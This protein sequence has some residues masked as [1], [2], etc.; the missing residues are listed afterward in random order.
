LHADP[1]DEEKGTESED[2]R[3]AKNCGQYQVQSI[4]PIE[5]PKA[6]HPSHDWE[7]PGAMFAGSKLVGIGAIR[8][9]LTPGILNSVWLVHFSTDSILEISSRLHSFEAYLCPRHSLL[10]P[11]S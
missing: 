4:S 11:R 7:A 6:L 10:L 1:G 5:L 9:L 3:T 2:K 8:N